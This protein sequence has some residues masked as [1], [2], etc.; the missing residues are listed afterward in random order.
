MSSLSNDDSRSVPVPRQRKP[1][2]LRK[3][4][5]EE[6]QR[7]LA[8]FARSGQSL[9]QFCR[10]N[11]VAL[12][13]LTYWRREARRSA[14]GKLEGVLVEVPPTVVRPGSLRREA[15]LSPGTVEIRLPNRVELSVA[16]DAWVRDLLRE[17][18]TCSG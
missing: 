7:V 15:S 5:A 13:S 4:S 6:R 1:R 2:A 11:D 16:A 8:L 14:P 10:E 9:K 12:S 3:R 18:L 17:V